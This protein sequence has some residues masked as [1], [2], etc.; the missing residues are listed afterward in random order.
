MRYLPI[1]NFSSLTF[2]DLVIL[3]IKITL[4]CLEFTKSLM[5]FNKGSKFPLVCHMIHVK[6][7]YT[8]ET[9]KVFKNKYMLTI[10]SF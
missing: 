1:N 9:Q 6:T 5:L 3:S 2:T 8:L 7:F 10:S 4:S